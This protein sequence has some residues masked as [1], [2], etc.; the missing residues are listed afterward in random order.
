VVISAVLSEAVR[1]NRIA[2]N[3][4][5]G[6]RKPAATRKRYPHPF[7][8]VVIE[9]IR[10]GM[11]ARTTKRPAEHRGKAD[12]CLVGLMSYAGLR[13]A[14]A[15]ALRWGDIG[16]RTITV[17]KAVRDGAE[18]S[19]KTT[20]LRVPPLATTLREDLLDFRREVGSPDDTQLIFP[21]RS[22]GHWSRSEQNN[23]RNRVWGPIVQDLATGEHPLPQVANSRPY[24]CRATFVSLNLRA[25]K[26]PVQV[27]LWAGHS[28]AVM[29]QHYAH[30]IEELD[31][32][33]E[34]SVD[35]QILRA[36]EV[37]AGLNQLQ[38]DL[39]TAELMERPTV[40]VAGDRSAAAVVYATTGLEL[41]GQASTGPGVG[42]AALVGADP[43]A[44]YTDG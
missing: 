23:W 27:A 22:G 31:A 32:E 2:T 21:S 14:E 11:R 12:S 40:A 34:L 39:F 28:Q 30:V 3:P 38:L 29:F 42:P 44:S 1:W 16:E 24:D 35:A 25:R 41:W 36:R 9:R 7:P 17:D 33:P 4:L 15:L 8:P 26:S 10:L 6:Q 5:W 43:S 37:I 18:A 20:N 19:T 13:P